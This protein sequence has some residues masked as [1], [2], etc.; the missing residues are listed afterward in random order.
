MPY[1]YLYSRYAYTD[2]YIIQ[3][4]RQVYK[5]SDEQVQ[6]H[7]HMGAQMVMGMQVCKYVVILASQKV[8]SN[9]SHLEH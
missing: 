3:V 7:G 8:V 6:E 5:L 9:Q 1:V 4:F 2:W